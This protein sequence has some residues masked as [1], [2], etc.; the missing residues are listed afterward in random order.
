MSRRT[1]S[2][3]ELLLSLLYVL[4]RLLSLLMR[5]IQYA[6]GVGARYL[7][8]FAV[9]LMPQESDSE[10]DDL[11]M[12]RE[13][14]STVT[15]HMNR[16]DGNSFASVP[17]VR[18]AF[19]GGEILQETT[20]AESREEIEVSEMH[21]PTVL[22]HREW[23]ARD[24]RKFYAVARGVRAGIFRK[25]STYSPFVDGFPNALHN[26]LEL[27]EKPKITCVAMA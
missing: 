9:T 24:K 26:A 19:L 13:Q 22:H 11:P 7:E 1:S 2:L 12:M 20:E 5:Y 6:T 16:R 18:S 17:D 14:R 8:Q 23:I 3:V 4:V 15:L 10:A 25:W 21:A 27:V